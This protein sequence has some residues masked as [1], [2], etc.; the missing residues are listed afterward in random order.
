MKSKSKSATPRLPPL[1]GKLSAATSPMRSTAACTGPIE[2]LIVSDVSANKRSSCAC[3][4][5]CTLDN[6]TPA[7][8]RPI[9]NVA[10]S[11]APAQR[12]TARVRPCKAQI[13]LR[14]YAIGRQNAAD[15]VIAVAARDDQ[16]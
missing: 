11:P 1:S 2:A 7:K 6:V 8:V 9:G 3:K 14:L 15:E 4:L 12:E 16:G 13:E 10:S 5:T